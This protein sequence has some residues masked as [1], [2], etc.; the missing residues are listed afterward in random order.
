MQQ[1]IASAAITEQPD[2]IAPATTPHT[3][4]GVAESLMP[5]VMLLARGP[6]TGTLALAFLCA[7]VLECLLK[8]Y[9][10]K[11]G[12]SDASLRKK[13]IRHDLNALWSLAGSHGLRVPA[14][15]PVWA[16]CLS[17]LHGPPYYL[18]YST[19]VH[20]IVSPAAE[21]MASELAGLLELVREQLQ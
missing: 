13:S 1:I 5:G 11:V 7:H 15:P 17:G 14:T 21:P 3:S 2:T 18:R 16:A 10:S 8:S 6:A 20:A 19:G 4:F 12:I 9:L